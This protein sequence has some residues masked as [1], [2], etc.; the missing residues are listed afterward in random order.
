MVAADVERVL[1]VPRA[2][3]NQ[4]L[5]RLA[6]KG[7]LLRIR[8]G[9][10]APVPLGAA[11]TRAGIEDP[12]LVAMAMYSPGYISGW[13]AAEHW[14]LTEQIFNAVSVVTAVPQRSTSQEHGGVS[15]HVRT[16]SPAAIFG[17]KQIWLGS[18]KVRVADPTRV[19]IDVLQAPDLGGG[20]RH[21]LDIVRNYWRSAHAD[22]VR[23]LEYA[24]QLGVGAV[25]KRLGYTAERFA[26]TSDDWRERC[27]NGMSAGVSRLDPTGPNRG[28]IVTSWRLRVNAPVDDT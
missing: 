15:F 27:R 22:P 11:T 1:T 24:E 3:A 28:R 16:V 2:T 8:R 21:T 23:A 10:Y 14:D 20:M 4:I 9:L 18:S 6:A 5:Q 7:W 19:V 13:S 12:W 26:R 17:V 25:F